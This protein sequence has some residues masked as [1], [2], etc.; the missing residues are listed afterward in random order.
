MAPVCWHCWSRA[1]CP[2]MRGAMAG[3]RIIVLA[4]GVGAARFLQGV[5][6]VT[7]P[8]DVT[9]LSNVGD[10]ETI[11]GVHVSP[12]IDIVTYTL[13]GVV[14]EDRGFGLAGDTFRVVEGLTHLG[15]EGW[16]RLGDRDFATCLFR[17]LALRE[18]RPLS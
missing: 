9:V 7:P 18:G 14:D 3:D 16:F 11:Y 12:D 1:T 8:A 6:A 5:L 13:A 2:G 4:G 17:T 15:G 10:D